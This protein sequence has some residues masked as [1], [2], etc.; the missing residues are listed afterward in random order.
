MYRLVASYGEVVGI[1]GAPQA[2]I[3]GPETAMDR[4]LDELR[5]A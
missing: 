2:G 4:R 5:G 1:V 3:V